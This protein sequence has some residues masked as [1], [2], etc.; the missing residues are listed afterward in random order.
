[1][2]Y[3]MTDPCS[4]CPFRSDRIFPLMPGRMRGIVEAGSFPCHKTLD[5]DGEAGESSLSC[6]GL[7]IL[8]EKEDRPNQIR[9]K[10][11]MNAPVYDTIEECIEGV[12][13]IGRP[14][15]LKKKGPRMKYKLPLAV[16][17]FIGKEFPVE[18]DTGEP[19]IVETNERS[20]TIN[21]L[22]EDYVIG[23]L[24]PNRTGRAIFKCTDVGKW[25][26]EL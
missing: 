9:T 22:K 17:G 14:L 6:A 7:M 15:K 23:I 3:S 10:L 21:G 4:R 5:E 16:K 24:A 20:E 26:V 1:M 25:K 8:L 19:L 11:N 12:E 18:N 13:E 2:D